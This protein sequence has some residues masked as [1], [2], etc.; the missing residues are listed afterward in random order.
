MR[1]FRYVSWAG[2]GVS[3]SLMENLSSEIAIDFGLIQEEFDELATRADLTA[4]EKA[5]LAA[6]QTKLKNYE[7][8]DQ[9]RPGSRP[10]RCRDGD[11]DARADR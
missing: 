8:T 10:D 6:L 5:E 9:G 4:A 2:N 1:V 3:H 11:N 7:R